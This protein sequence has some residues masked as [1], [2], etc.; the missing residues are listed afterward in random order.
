MRTSAPDYFSLVHLE[1]FFMDVVS[2]KTPPEKN[3]K[4]PTT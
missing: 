4:N 1:F 2:F 3:D